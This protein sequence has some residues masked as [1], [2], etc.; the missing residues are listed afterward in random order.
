MCELPVAAMAAE[1]HQFAVANIFPRL[2]RVR[3]TDDVL[4]ALKPA[5]K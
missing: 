3:S 5:A 2:G 1:A 4:K